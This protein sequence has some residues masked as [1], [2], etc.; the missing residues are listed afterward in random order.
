MS[1]KRVIALVIGCVMIL[2]AIGVLFG[3]GAL[4][5]AYATQR[6]DD[7]YFDATIDQLQ[8]PTAAITGENLRFATDAGS[9]DWLIDTIDLDVRIRATALDSD[10]AVFIGL[11]RQRDLDRYLADVAHDRVIRIENGEPV[12][13]RHG[14]SVDPLA[15]PT[16]QDVWVAQASG[17]GT[18]EL[19]WSATSGRWAAV[20]MNADGSPGVSVT[21]TVGGK[22][23]II[24]PLALALTGVG[25]V[26]T[27]AAVVLI[28]YGA[29]GA[30][31]RDD[32]VATSSA[33]DVPPAGAS[34]LPP[35]HAES[36]GHSSAE[37]ASR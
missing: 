26:L 23:G 21:M 5:I 24:L 30:R 34:P 35:P 15:S 27:A 1:T 37:T 3:G 20:V 4:A 12:Y 11:A 32:T 17:P 6:N 28:V 2:P 8:T 29:S 36:A 18:Q 31:R 25:A 7:G 9:P 16:E 10:Q 19:T 33:S 22:S 14:G 13:R